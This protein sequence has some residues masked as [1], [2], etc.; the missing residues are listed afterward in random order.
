MTPV[1]G[2]ATIVSGKFKGVIWAMRTSHRRGMTPSRSLENTPIFRGMDWT[3]LAPRGS[4]ALRS[5][6]QP[7]KLR[8]M[9][10]CAV[11]VG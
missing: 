7:W 4:R 5:R 3:S 2:L 8:P 10:S 1:R 11:Y 6:L 9:L